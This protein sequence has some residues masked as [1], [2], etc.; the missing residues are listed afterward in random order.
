MAH[1]RVAGADRGGGDRCALWSRSPTPAGSRWRWLLF[2]FAAFALAALV[3]EFVRGVAARRA[4]TGG[5]VPAALGAIVT[6][7]RRRYGGYIVHA[8]IAILF[9]AVAA[10]SSFQTTRDLRL[11]PGPER[12]RRRL[13]TSPTSEPTESIDPVEQ[14]LTLR[15]R[16]RRAPRRDASS[17]SCSPSRNYYPARRTRRSGPVRGFFEGEATS[18]V[19]LRTGPPAATSGPRCSPTC[20]LDGPSSSAADRRLSRLRKALPPND[21]QRAARRLRQGHA[22]RAIADRYVCDPPPAN[23]RVNVNPLVIWIWIGGAIA[24]VG[25]L[26]APVAGRRRAPPPRLGRVRG[27]AGPR[28]GQRLTPLAAGPSLSPSHGVLLSRWS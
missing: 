4:L 20:T 22:I 3:Q 10:S 14:R 8:G 11:T 13:S 21:P 6:R 24:L 1:V 16:A 9:I 17:R 2:A 12:E 23:F 25:A 7:N 28:P 5:S 26:I 27:A 15:R 19:G 18:E